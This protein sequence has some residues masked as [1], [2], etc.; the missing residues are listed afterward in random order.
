MRDRLFQQLAHCAQ[1]LFDFDGVHRR[2]Q[3]PLPQQPPAHPGPRLIEHRQHGRLRGAARGFDIRREHRLGQFQVAHRHRVQHHRIG[4]VIPGGPVQVIERRPLRL[5]QVMQNGARRSHRRRPAAQSAAV[6]RQQSEVIPQR[7]ARVIRGEYP[8]LDL[9][10]HEARRAVRGRRRRQV[11]GE[12]HLFRRQLLQRPRHFRRIHLG[13][14][15]LAGRNVHVRH[16]RP[17]PCRRHRRQVIV[18]VRPQQARIHRRAWCYHPRQF[19]PHQ[20]LGQLRVFHLVADGDPV[21]LLDQ[22]RDVGFRRV[23]RHAAHR[24]R[25]AFFLVARGERDLQVARGDHRVLEEQLVEIAQ[26]E[27]QKGVRHLLLDAVVLPHQRRR[28]VSRHRTY[29]S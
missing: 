27:H 22:P 21:P 19:A 23:V 5:A 4:A 28:S 7:A 1:P 14:P 8:F 6:Q 15:K 11:A 12:Q 16:A 25:R 13:H 2:P 26:P 17:S 20:R 9:G 24:N 29:R 18:F 3:Q 10:P